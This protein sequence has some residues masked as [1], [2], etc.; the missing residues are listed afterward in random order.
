MQAKDFCFW[1]QGMFEV[2]DPKELTSEQVAIIKQHLALVFKHD[3]TM[4]HPAPPTTLR[5]F[6]EP[7]REPDK[8]PSRIDVYC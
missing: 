8:F 3:P 1:L 6:L 4:A 2:V 5:P 7:L